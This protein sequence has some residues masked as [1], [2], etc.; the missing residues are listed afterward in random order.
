MYGCCQ[1]SSMERKLRVHHKCLFM[2]RSSVSSHFS[3]H[4]TLPYPKIYIN[5]VHMNWIQRFSHLYSQRSGCRRKKICVDIV[6]WRQP[7]NSKRD[8]KIFGSESNSLTSTNVEALVGWINSW[9]HI[10]YGE[11]GQAQSIGIVAKKSEHLLVNF[12]WHVAAN[13][14]SPT[15]AVNT[16]EIRRQFN[17]FIV[18]TLSIYRRLHNKRCIY[19][20]CFPQIWHTIHYWPYLTREISNILKCVYFCIIHIYTPIPNVRFWFAAH[21]YLM[22]R[23]GTISV[24]TWGSSR[25]VNKFNT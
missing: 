2:C 14:Y 22:I 1:G 16:F 5:W 11:R 12:S 24:D 15:H 10:V 21:T 7:N 25:G 3:A 8:S 17:I 6:I 4:Q 13:T 18:I 20:Q 23:S 19:R 9:V